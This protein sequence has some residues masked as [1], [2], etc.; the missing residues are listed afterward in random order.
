MLGAHTME[1]LCTDC[2]GDFRCL[3]RDILKRHLEIETP[4]WLAGSIDE[5]KNKLA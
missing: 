4:V 1:K 5:A 3:I 2:G